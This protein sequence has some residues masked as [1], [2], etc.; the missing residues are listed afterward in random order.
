MKELDN[1]MGK[2]FARYGELN[3][4]FS[5]LEL[6]TSMDKKLE[7]ASKLRRLKSKYNKLYLSTK[8]NKKLHRNKSTQA[9]LTLL[10]N[11]INKR[12]E[13]LDLI[14][15]PMTREESTSVDVD[16]FR[17]ITEVANEIDKRISNHLRRSE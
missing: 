17:K 12:E 4:Q 6:D 13:S 1:L 2:I 15:D 3:I 9:F 14:I 8:N 5:N 10:S 16:S 7:N 11:A